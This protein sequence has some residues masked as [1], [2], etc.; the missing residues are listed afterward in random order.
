ME[1]EFYWVLAERV[2]AIAEKADP[3]TRRRL[4]DLATGTMQGAVVPLDPD[5]LSA[6]CRYLAR[7]PRFRTPLDR[8]KSEALQKIPLP[9]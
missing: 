7:S 9:A 4:L 6:P 8:A 2:R 5:R 3:F 1:Q